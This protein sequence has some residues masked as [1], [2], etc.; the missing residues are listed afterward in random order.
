MVLKR[1]Q[2]KDAQ[3]ANVL[4]DSIATWLKKGTVEDKLKNKQ[5][6]MV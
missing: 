5:E 1:E 2:I 3:T 4:D 6:K